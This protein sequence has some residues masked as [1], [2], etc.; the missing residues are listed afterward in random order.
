MPYDRVSPNAEIASRLSTSFKTVD[1]HVSA[2][3]AK[4]EVHSRAQAITKAQALGLLKI[5]DRSA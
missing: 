5:E 4:L 3:L 1:H 2:I